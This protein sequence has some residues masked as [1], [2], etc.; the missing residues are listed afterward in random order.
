MSLAVPQ[1]RVRAARAADLAD[2]LELRTLAG[3]GFTSFMISEAAFASRLALSEAS[4]AATPTAPGKERYLLALEHLPSGKVVGSA[5]VK[6]TVGA[7]PPF[8]NFR[9]LTIAQH[10]AA[11]AQRFDM[12]VL[13]LVNEFTGASEVGSLFVRPEHRSGGAGRLL[14]QARYL[15]MAADPARFNGEVVSELRGVVDADGNTPFWDAL[16]RH[17]FKMSFREADQLSATTDNQFILDLMPKYPIYVDLLPPAARAV[18]GQCHEDGVGARRLL[19]AEGFRYD[20][21]VDIFDGGP[22][23]STARDAIR[24]VRE[25]QTL[26][27][28]DGEPGEGARPGLMANPEFSSFGVLSATFAIAGD[29]VVVPAATLA[30]LGLEPGRSALVWVNAKL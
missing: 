12:D 3:P 7:T 20:Y 30:A 14:A 13:I 17:F 15:L 22:L 25:A 4:F 10:S 28:R 8:F 11:A 19:E 2:F 1:Y 24:T 26:I 16:G 5:A 29:T 6:A 27:I 9:V 21:V 23:V 18:I